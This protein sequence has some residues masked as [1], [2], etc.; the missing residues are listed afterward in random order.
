M[1][2]SYSMAMANKISYASAGVKYELLDPIKI[3]AQKKAVDTRA[4]LLPFQE[5]TE[6]RG[7]S[8]FVWDEGL[9]YKAFVIEGLGTKNLVAD[10]MEKLTGAT[11]Y[12]AIAQ[13]T[14]AMIVNDIIVV[15]AKPQVINAYFAVG[16]SRWMANQKRSTALVKGWAKACQ[17]SG[18]TWGGGETPTLKGIINPETIDLGG[19]CIG[20]IKPKKR[21]CLGDKL[22]ANDRIVLI[23]S[24]G[25]HANGLTLARTIAS[26]LNNGYLTPLSN[27]KTF[28]EEL[29]KPTHIYAQLV[30]QVYNLGVFPHYMVNITGHGWRK[31]MRSK[32][33]FSYVIDTIPP[34]SP[35]FEFI[36]KHSGNDLKE[37]YGNFNMGAGF[38]LFVAKKDV[39]K[40]LEAAKKMKLKAWDAGSVELG[41]KKVVIKPLDIVYTES[42]LEVR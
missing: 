13:D 28:G 8:A 33:S 32:Q 16:D 25:I 39:T 5:I 9:A 38:G 31:L 37:M 35:L 3:L 12:K 14:V 36:Q 7:E 30:E 23:E 27:G 15:G 20:I 1:A 29:L 40:V 19:S 17:L 42:E 22:A 4:N 21:L 6:S 2:F 18:A 26:R 41:E 10:E 34:M 11:F 24:N